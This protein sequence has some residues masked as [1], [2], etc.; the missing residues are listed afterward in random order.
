MCQYRIILIIEALEYVMSDRAG[1]FFLPYPHLFGN[2]F[3]FVFQDFPSYFVFVF[4][5]LIISSQFAYH[6]SELFL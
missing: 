2:F 6:V 4:Y 5:E 1:S 3:A